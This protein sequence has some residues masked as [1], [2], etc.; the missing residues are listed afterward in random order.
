MYFFCL[1]AHLGVN[2]F[3]LFFWES[4]NKLKINLIDF[5][6]VKSVLMKIVESID[7]V[8]DAVG[9]SGCIIHVSLA[10]RHVVPAFPPSTHPVFI[11]AI[12]RLEEVV[13][14]LPL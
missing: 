1:F 13:F 3:G 12:C 5:L 14:F 11:N 2:V 7:F 4:R 8:G 6:C 10:R 9:A